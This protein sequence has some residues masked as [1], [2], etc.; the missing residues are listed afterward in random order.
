VPHDDPDAFE[1]GD[2]VWVDFGSPMGHE[3][4]GRRPALVVSP[5]SYNENSSLI[6]VCPITRNAA[7]WAFKV[8]IQNADRIAG[9]ILV[10]QV[11]SI[12]HQGRF[13][14][15]ADRVDVETLD[16]VYGL[17]AA[18]LGIPVSN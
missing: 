13:A 10:D 7:P 11:R 16:Q 3:Q 15:R 6:L 1:A 12:D 18:L 4:A 5:R 8:E 14:R 2:I 17:F 9:A